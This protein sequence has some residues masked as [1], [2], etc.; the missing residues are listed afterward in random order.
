MTVS[1]PVITG[2]VAT[3]HTPVDGDRANAG[4]QPDGIVGFVADALAAN[5]T[6]KSPGC[7]P[8]PEIS[9][10]VLAFDAAPTK[11]IVISQPPAQQPQQQRLTPEL[12]QTFGILREPL[13]PPC[14]E[15]DPE[16]PASRPVIPQQYAVP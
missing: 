10:D 4:V 3:T 6:N 14:F 9:T 1:D 11:E 5:T 7:M 12:N 8:S 2:R 15:L 13:L 16:P